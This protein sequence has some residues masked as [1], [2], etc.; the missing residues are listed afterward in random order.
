MPLRL[1][2]TI[3]AVLA[4]ALA[5]GGVWLFDVGAEKTAKAKRPARAATTLVLVDE[6]DLTELRLAMHAIGTGEAAKSAAIHPSVAGEVVEVAFTAEQRVEAGALLI[7]LDDKHQRLAVRLAKVTVT[8]AERQYRRILQLAP[9]GAA[10][11]ARLEVT[12]ADLE[13]AKVVLSQAEAD[14]GDRSIRAPFAGVVSLSNIDRGDR[15]TP[16]TVIATLDDRS[17]IL[18]DF[19]APE[20]YAGRI[21]P[22][23]AISLRPWTMPDVTLQG[24]VFATGS[25]IDP[26]S[27][28]LRVRV[29]IPNT[30]DSIRPGTSFEVRKEFVGDRYPSVREVA[31]LWSRDG[32]YLWRVSDGLAEKVFVKMVRRD[33]GR[34]LVKGP[35]SAGDLIVVEGVQGLRAGQKV[36]VQPFET[37]GTPAPAVPKDR[38]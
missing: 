20:D 37:Q 8:K 22:G 14:L 9:S 18:V 4:A 26:K 32:A 33:Q 2:I 1:Q 38:T 23:D 12:E 5:A 21:K 17:T 15:V 10:S 34:V 11:R 35:L 7:R 6:V 29:Q 36:N 24:T 3:V 28:S 30:D 19:N 25:R 16:D 31:V 27:R 13:A